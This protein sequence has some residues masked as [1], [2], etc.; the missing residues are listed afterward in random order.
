MSKYTNGDVQLVSILISRNPIARQAST[1][2]TADAAL[3]SFI[4]AR[5]VELGD[6]V[7]SFANFL[8]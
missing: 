5:E 4:K 7:D 1:I 8:L 3:A 2:T 6:F